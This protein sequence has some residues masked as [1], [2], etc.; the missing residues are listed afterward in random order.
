MD[1]DECIRALCAEALAIAGHQV[2]TAAN[3]VEALN[4]LEEACDIVVTDMNMPGLGGLALYR[5]ALEQYP[6]LERRFVFM[7]GDDCVGVRAAL[8]REDS[9]CLLKPFKIKELIDAVETAGKAGYED[10]YT[11]EN[12]GRRSEQ[13]FGLT[14]GC[15]VEGGAGVE[16][17]TAP[18]TIE[19][20]SRNG[21]EIRYAGEPLKHGHGLS[22]SFSVGRMNTVRDAEVVW[23]KSAGGKECLAGVRLTEPIPVYWILS[24]APRMDNAHNY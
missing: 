12:R 2:R 8:D 17:R 6:Y 4:S 20:V 1:D 5:M 10:L 22:I 19:N 7:T 14:V 21:L 13:R 16:T 24:A 3:G 18:A 11:R 23:S 9:I 15:E